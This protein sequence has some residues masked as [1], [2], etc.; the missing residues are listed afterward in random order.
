MYVH[1]II[2]SNIVILHRSIAETIWRQNQQT[3][4]FS[5]IVG[6]FGSITYVRRRGKVPHVKS[7]D[8]QYSVQAGQQA[9]FILTREQNM[10]I[11]C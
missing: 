5:P 1:V 2:E 3:N 4:L 9:A 8:S 10:V 7:V 11:A 6:V